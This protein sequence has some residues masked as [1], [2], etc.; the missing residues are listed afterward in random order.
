MLRC[1]AALPTI[2]PILSHRSENWEVGVFDDLDLESKFDRST[3]PPTGL[4][5]G[6]GT[7]PLAVGGSMPTPTP[8]ISHQT[9]RARTANSWKMRAVSPCAPDPPTRPAEF[10]GMT[11]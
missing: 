5:G 9:N 4:I 10:F 3:N 8:G 1:C 7:I 11:A 6:I 2:L